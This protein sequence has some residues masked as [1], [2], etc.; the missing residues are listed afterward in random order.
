MTR[1]RGRAQARIDRAERER[2]R[3]RGHV[4]EVV[5]RGGRAEGAVEGRA[6]G[7]RRQRLEHRGH[8]RGQHGL[9]DV[10]ELVHAAADV[11]TEPAEEDLVLEVGAELVPVFGVG[12]DGEVERRSAARCRRSAGCCSRPM[13]FVLPTS[14]S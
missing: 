11:E 7:V 6:E 3:D 10:A 4:E 1:E 14:R 5:D 9:V 13:T 12:R 2:A 8:A